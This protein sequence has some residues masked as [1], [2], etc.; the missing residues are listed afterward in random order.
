MASGK[1]FEMVMD[2]LVNLKSD[3]SQADKITKEL[4]KQMKS[5]TPDINIDSGKLKKNVLELIGEFGKLENGIDELDKMVLLLLLPLL[6][7][8]LG[9]M[10]LQPI[11]LL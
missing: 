9:I 6:G 2:F 3:K 5:I 8:L 4:E 1:R 11:G 7:M 10:V